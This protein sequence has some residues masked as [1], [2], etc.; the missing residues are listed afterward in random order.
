MRGLVW[1]VVPQRTMLLWCQWVVQLVFAVVEDRP[2]CRLA[3]DL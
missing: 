1:W 3:W 2:E